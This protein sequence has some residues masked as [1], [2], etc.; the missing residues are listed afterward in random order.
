MSSPTI[1][2]HRHCTAAGRPGRHH[3]SQPH[4]V[5]VAI[6]RELRLRF[7]QTPVSYQDAGPD[8]AV[9]PG[10]PGLRV[11]GAHIDHPAGHAACPVLVCGPA[12]VRRHGAVAAA[13]DDEAGPGTIVRYAGSQA[14]R[15]DVALRAVHVWTG[16]QMSAAG[17]RAPGQDEVSDA[18]RLLAAA[19]YRDLPDAEAGDAERQILHDA[20]PVRALVA[21]SAGLSL[22]VVGARTAGATTGCDVLGSTARGLLGR[23]ACP[24]AVLPPVAEDTAW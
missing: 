20:D 13:V 19:L 2:P 10:G 23:T 16:R 15:L 14:R 11:L 9:P 24:L 12:P 7:P 3:H 8:A 21:L 1:F 4:D 22:L 17:V 18:D 5:A 6:M